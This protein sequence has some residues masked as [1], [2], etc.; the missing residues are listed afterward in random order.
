M[1]EE[2]GEMEVIG[3]GEGKGEGKGGQYEELGAYVRGWVEEMERE[4]ELRKRAEVSAR[5]KTLKKLKKRGKGGKGRKKEKRRKGRKEIKGVV[6]RE[7][8][9]GGGGIAEMEVD[10]FLFVFWVFFAV[11]LPSLLVLLWLVVMAESGVEEVV[12]EWREV[13]GASR[14]L[15]GEV[16]KALDGGA[17][18]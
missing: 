4:I 3:E 10:V 5:E 17:R 15:F 14:E 16:K 13:L 1:G 6:G 12:E 8:K 9:D 2:G 7:K 11:C 18:C